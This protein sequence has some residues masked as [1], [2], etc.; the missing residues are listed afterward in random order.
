[1]PR[2]KSD[3]PDW[4]RVTPIRLGSQIRE[5]LEQLLAADR[6]AEGDHSLTLSH[7]IRRLIREEHRRRFQGR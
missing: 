2:K 6:N 3:P 7:I 5:M 4:T 1:M